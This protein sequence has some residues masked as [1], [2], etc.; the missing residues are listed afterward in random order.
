MSNEHSA[1]WTTLYRYFDK[2]GELLYVG[3]TSAWHLRLKGHSAR[4]PWW[5]RAATVSLTHYQTRAEALA[6]EARAISHEHPLYNRAHSRLTRTGW[7]AGSVFQRRSGRDAG[8]WVA[9]L[10]LEDGRRPSRY[11]NTREEAQARLEAL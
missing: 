5:L 4:S 10:L 7:G 8:K 6:E 2:E 11:A 1:V 9:V 3:I